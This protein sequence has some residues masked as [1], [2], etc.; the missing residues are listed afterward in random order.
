MGELPEWLSRVLAERDELL[1]KI[2]KLSSFIHSNK[3]LTVDEL[4]FSL[5]KEQLTAMQA[6]ESI[7]T[8]RINLFFKGK[9]E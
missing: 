7:L 8:K 5:L 6:Y 9:T 1:V 3:E 2:N 4:A